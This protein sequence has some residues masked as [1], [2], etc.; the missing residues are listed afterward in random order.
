MQSI[1]RPHADAGARL[2]KRPA[3]DTRTLATLLAALLLASVHLLCARLRVLGR[4]PRSRWLS[5][6]GGVA[7]AYVFLHLLPEI[8]HGQRLIDERA[9]GPLAFLESHAYLLA[10][11]GLVAFYGVERLAKRHRRRI[12]TGARP[13]IAVFWLHIASFAAYNAL[14]GYLLLHREE[15]GLGN[16]AWFTAAMAMHFL[17][18]DFGLQSDHRERYDHKGRWLL[19]AA[20]LLGWALGLLIE[21]SDVAISAW[22]ALLAGGV[23]LN[24]LK[25]ELPA[26]RDSRFSA[27]VVGAGGYALVLLAL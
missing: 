10:L 14:T 24:V 15:A 8:A 26:E 22:L 21:I 12:V 20:L 9:T 13:S 19:A 25:E 5:F 4:Q 23:I 27:F 18:N 3:M 17:V 16:L 2:E 11:A 1:P 7:V 6:A